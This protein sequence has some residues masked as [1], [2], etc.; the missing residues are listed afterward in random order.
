MPINMTRGFG[1]QRGYPRAEIPGGVVPMGGATIT[2]AASNSPRN[3]RRSADFTCNGSSDEST[4][5]QAIAALPPQGG[6]VRLV[7][8]KYRVSNPI[9]IARSR[10]NLYGDGFGFWGGFAGNYP[11]ADPEGQGIT[12]IEC[13]S[14]V[15]AITLS[16]PQGVPTL[17]AR[18][19]GIYLHDMYLYGNAHNANGIETLSGAG[20]VDQMIIERMFCHNFNNGMLL[21]VDSGYINKST[22]MDL[23][24]VGIDITASFGALVTENVL[25]DLNGE[26]IIGT[27]GNNGIIITN[28]ELVRCDH[29]ASSAAIKVNSIS[30][31][32]VVANNTITSSGGGGILCLATTSTI[33]SNFIVG[34]GAY[35]IGVNA[36]G[37]QTTITGNT[38]A[39]C[40]TNGIG[41]DNTDSVVVVG[42]NIRQTQTS[43]GFINIGSNGICHAVQVGLNALYQV[44]GTCAVG[45]IVA[46]S[47]TGLTCS[48]VFHGTVT[49]LVTAASLTNTATNTNV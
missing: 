47:S 36:G 42:N 4:I 20:N 17:D 37:A 3:A 38:I 48:N 8:G 18:L 40:T 5:N 27:A 16:D 41:V 9:S 32:S 31:G 25:S 10:V 13:T 19:N 30:P 28:N 11:T 34:S 46:N 12:L 21:T 14:A 7:A 26:G 22:C 15:D 23:T 43:T 49:L 2:V 6:S 33:S 44:S 24:G 39:N 45:I 1:L 29:A 35:G